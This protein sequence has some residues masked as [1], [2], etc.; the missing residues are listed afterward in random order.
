MMKTTGILAAT[1]LLA[2][3]F[4]ACSPSARPRVIKETPTTAVIEVKYNNVK[5]GTIFS[6]DGYPSIINPLSYEFDLSGNGCDTLTIL[7][8][9]PDKSY[10]FIT[11]MR[12]GSSTWTGSALNVHTAKASDQP[13]DLGLSVLW[14]PFNLGAQTLFGHGHYLAWGELEM[15]ESYTP[16]TYT[17][18]DGYGIYP[19]SNTR[20]DFQLSPDK[21]AAVQE[22]GDGWRIPTEAEFQ[23]LID[24]CRWKYVTGDNNR[25]FWMV[26]GPNDNVLI[27]PIA[28]YAEHNQI[29]GLKS[30]VFL[31]GKYWAANSAECNYMNKGVIHNCAKALTLNERDV[32]ILDMERHLGLNI[33]PVKDKSHAAAA[34]SP[35]TESS[36]PTQPEA[37]H[38]PIPR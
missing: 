4:S 35:A 28:G 31:S 16:Q 15:K 10:D 30:Y 19:T 11:S 7:G 34:A 27:L 2:F 1:G 33:R 22:L 20:P 24:K 18:L 32:R 8:L 5:P 25:H 12:K 36:E 23:E 21:D 38:A 29:L 26:T 6:I 37:P 3:L 17:Y 14:A 13:V 9:T